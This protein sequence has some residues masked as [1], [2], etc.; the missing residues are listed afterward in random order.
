MRAHDIPLSKTVLAILRR[1]PRVAGRG[2]IFGEGEH[3]FQGFSKAKAALDARAKL[4]QPWQL[5]DLRR[6]VV[7]GMGDI[8][9]PPHV[10]EA[11]VNHVSGTKGGVA[12]VYNKSVYSKE[13]AAALSRWD[14]ELERL[15]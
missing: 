15:T 2:F 13:K 9:V 10:V 6:T 4:N 5:R 14:T 11:V 12:G 1:Q 8:E 7:T 3:G